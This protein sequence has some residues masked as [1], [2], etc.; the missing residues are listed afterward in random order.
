VRAVLGLVRRARGDPRD[1]RLQ[2]DGTGGAGLIDEAGAST[3][4]EC[5][6]ADYQFEEQC[7]E[8]VHPPAI[9]RDLRLFELDRV[10]WTYKGAS[11]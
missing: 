4:E 10:L 11:R 1:R 9:G 2:A 6:G 5:G 7:A 8:V 3:C